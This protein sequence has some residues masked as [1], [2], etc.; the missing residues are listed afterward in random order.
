[1]RRISAAPGRKASSEP[2]S[3]AHGADDGVGDLRLDRA[4]VA[5]DIA[6]LDRKS[7]AC[8]FDHR[9]IAEQPGNARRIDGRRHDEELE[10]LA[11]ALLHVAGKRETEIG[12]ERAFMKLVEQHGGDAVEHRIVEDEP[13]EN[14]LGDDFDA[15]FTRH[16]GAEAHPQ[17]YG[18][19]DALAECRR[20]AL[21]GGAR[22]QPARLEHQDAAA[23][24]PVL[25]GQHQRHP[26]G[27]AGARRRHQN[28]RI[29]RAQGRGQA[30]QRGV[31]RQRRRIV[32]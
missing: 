3:A 32:H 31:N 6:R 10:I 8:A 5:A 30:R 19:A 7:A 12:I 28:R 20:H 1:M 17:A 25:A 4:R 23:F 27:L 11:Q 14:S 29:M 9:R 22:R 16:F 24:R 18:V 26:R 21:G 2:A 13:G 15:G